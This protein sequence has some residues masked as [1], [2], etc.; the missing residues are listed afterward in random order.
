M[1]GRR[2][3]PGEWEKKRRRRSTHTP[4]ARNN[5]KTETRGLTLAPAAP[6]SPGAGAGRPALPPS[7]PPSFTGSTGRGA[8]PS[9]PQQP[10]TRGRP[11]PTTAAAAA[12]P[13][14]GPTRHPRAGKGPAAAA[15]A[16]PSLTFSQLPLPHADDER[17]VLAVVDEPQAQGLHALLRVAQLRELPLQRRLRE[18]RHRRAALGS[19]PPAAASSSSSSSFSSTDPA[20]P[21][22]IPA[23]PPQQGRSRAGPVPSLPA[24]PAATSAH[25]DSPALTKWRRP[26]LPESRLAPPPFSSCPH[27]RQGPRTRRSGAGPR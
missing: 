15:A 19:A 25:P 17:R 12:T 20:R 4:P 3:E 8:L 23:S 18:R 26:N 10:H 9:S 21:R 11:P 16:V 27:F 14:A 2:K 7:L 6:F 22:S 5:Q 1:G 13:K 24:S